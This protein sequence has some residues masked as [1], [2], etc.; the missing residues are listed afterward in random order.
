MN[1]HWDKIFPLLKTICGLTRLAA[2]RVRLAA[3]DMHASECLPRALL[4]RNPI[5]RDSCPW[6][7]GTE[8]PGLLNFFLVSFLF[9]KHLPC[10]THCRQSGVVGGRP[11]REQ[12][13]DFLA[14]VKDT[15]VS[16]HLESGFWVQILALPLSGADYLISSCLSFLT[17]KVQPIIHTFVKESLQIFNELMPVKHIKHHLVQNGNSITVRDYYNKAKKQNVIEYKKDYEVNKIRS[18]MELCYSI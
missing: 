11:Y 14:G 7:S 8:K 12:V 2:Q 10:T 18:W 9:T 6:Q 17:K 16:W 13:R 3:C 1:S 15:Q 5:G 4:L